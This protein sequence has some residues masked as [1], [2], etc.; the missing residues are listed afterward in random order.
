MSRDIGQEK[1]EDNLKKVDLAGVISTVIV[2]A[3]GIKLIKTINTKE[4]IHYHIMIKPG[5]RY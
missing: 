4:V 5:G 1:K 3:V 2:L